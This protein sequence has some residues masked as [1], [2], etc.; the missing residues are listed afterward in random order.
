MV[1]P[2]E[3]IALVAASLTVCACVQATMFAVNLK[4]YRTPRF[5]P[6]G[7]TRVDVLI[8]TRDEESNIRQCV[9]SVLAS[10]DVDVRVIVGDGDSA[11]RTVRIVWSMCAQD[12]RVQLIHTGEA[13]SGWNPRVYS[14]WQMANAST[15]PVMLFLH[16]DVRLDPWALARCL[17][18]LKAKDT[19]L[20][21]GFPRLQV[22]GWLGKLVLPLVQFEMLTFLPLGRVRKTTKPRYAAG[23]G[24][25]LI[26]DREAYFG[27]GGHEAIRETMHDGVLL[28]RTFREHGYPTDVV[29]VT[30][31]AAVHSNKPART[32]WKDLAKNA[33]EGMAAPGRIVPLTLLMLLGQVFPLFLV[34]AWVFVCA[35]VLAAGATFDGVLS[36]IAITMILGIGIM[37]ALVPRLLAASR[38]KQSTLS[39]WLHPIGVLVLLMVQ[40]YAYV[41]ERLGK[42]INAQTR[43]YTYE[44]EEI[45]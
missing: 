33:T 41:R 43:E 26:V 10:E 2:L 42:P 19:K 44:R 29:D 3:A 24:Q 1:G 37:A 6:V 11:D 12:S 16:A 36:A 28:P 31:L 13:P 5:G 39:A 32:V 4:R 25:F 18:A 21:S 45:A 15:A 20:I 38:F 9:E 30:R 40:W 35:S 17:A 34:A 8:P 27:S 7:N 14:C 23:S 22:R